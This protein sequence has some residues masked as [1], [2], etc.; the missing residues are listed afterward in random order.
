MSQPGADAQ[1]ARLQLEPPQVKKI[2]PDVVPN[3]APVPNGEDR[4]H[5][6]NTSD[7]AGKFLTDVI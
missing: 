1:I 7:M 3:E 6:R 5:K 2:G 4:L